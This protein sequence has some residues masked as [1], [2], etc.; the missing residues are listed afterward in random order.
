MKNVLKSP[1]PEELKKYK[2]RYAFQFQ[3]WGN[4]QQNKKAYNA[5]RN[6]VV[7]DQKGLCAYYEI[8]LHPNDRCVEHFI[9]RHQSTPQNNYDLDWQNM[10]ANCK[11]GMENVRAI[12]F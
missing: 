7:S 11:G 9:P 6:T 2:K 4:L 3:R 10:L 8:D 12:S 5:T 1:Q